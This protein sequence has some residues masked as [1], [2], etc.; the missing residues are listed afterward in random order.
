MAVIA[1]EHHVEHPRERL[2][3]DVTGLGIIPRIHVL[4]PNHP[5]R[6]AKPQLV[7]SMPR[8]QPGGTSGPGALSS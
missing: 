6:Q 2:H 1:A 3:T 7:P 8:V 5:A 4:T